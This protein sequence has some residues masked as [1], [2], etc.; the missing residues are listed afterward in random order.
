MPEELIQQ[1]RDLMAS[2]KCTYIDCSIVC[3]CVFRVA[4][5]SKDKTLFMKHED[6]AI[7]RQFAIAQLDDLLRKYKLYED[8]NP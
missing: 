1:T 2:G 3:D 5:G 6:E 8:R 7:E 4:Y